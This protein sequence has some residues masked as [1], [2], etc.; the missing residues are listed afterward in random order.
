MT[1][2]VTLFKATAHTTLRIC[3]LYLKCCIVCICVLFIHYVCVYFPHSPPSELITG[4][5]N[6]TAKLLQ[7][8]PAGECSGVLSGK[9]LGQ[10]ALSYEMNFV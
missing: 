9:W 6:K 5:A 7:M 8:L 10:H 4:T 3:C 2:T 1:Y